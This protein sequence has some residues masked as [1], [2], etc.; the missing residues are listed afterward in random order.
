MGY[1]PGK[2]NTEGESALKEEWQSEY[3]NIDIRHTRSLTAPK[4]N[5][6]D[7]RRKPI[8]WREDMI[9][10]LHGWDKPWLLVRP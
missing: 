7:F 10:N 6:S 2:F 3:P 9:E 8:N 4:M 1:E 5:Y